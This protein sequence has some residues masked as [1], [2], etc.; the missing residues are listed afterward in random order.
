MR[1]LVSILVM[2]GC[3][4]GTPWL[5]AQ[6]ASVKQG[7]NDPFKNPDPKQFLGRFEKEGREVYNK[8]EQIVAALGLQPGWVVAD[9]GAGT[10]LFTR[11]MAPK[12]GPAGKVY[13]VDIAEKFVTYAVQ[14]SKE[15]GWNWVEGIVCAA[16][17]ARLPENAVDL[18]FICDTYHHFEFPLKTMASI[19]RSLKKG[20]KVVVV[21]FKREE[22]VST[23][24][25][26]KH[27]RA[28]KEVVIREI[29]QCGLILEDQPELLEEN[30]V[31]RFRK[32]ASAPQK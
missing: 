25:I 20:G 22:G 32:P 31:L 12:V 30:Y 19:Y 8:R 26:L 9:V 18:V 3:L 10:G 5:W 14:S 24:W 29:E 27:V 15:A 13:A 2:V 21:D 17:D 23:D 7:I 1:K 6:Q 16:D 28:G 4:G 11:I